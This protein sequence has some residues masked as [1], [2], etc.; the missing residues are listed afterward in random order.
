M[1][2]LLTYSNVSNRGRKKMIKE[3]EKQTGQSVVPWAG[4]KYL[5][6]RRR[7]PNVRIRRKKKIHTLFS[8]CCPVFLGARYHDGP[9]MH[10]KKKTLL[11]SRLRQ[12]FFIT[13]DMR[14]KKKKKMRRNSN[15][16]QW[17]E[18]KNAGG[19]RRHHHATDPL[20]FCRH[21]AR[22]QLLKRFFFLFRQRPAS[23]RVKVKR[24]KEDS[25]PTHGRVVA[26]KIIIKKKKNLR[27]WL[28]IILL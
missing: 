25:G 7:W 20:C 13:N 19:S 12:S 24:K 6:P 3:G 16:H 23:R 14:A 9:V 27:W 21:I 1:E 15:F 5:Q 10:K 2:P 17:L 18:Q 28:M 26:F 8:A 4:N 11:F 22:A